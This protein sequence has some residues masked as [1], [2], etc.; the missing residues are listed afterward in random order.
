MGICAIRSAFA[1]PAIAVTRRYFFVA[2]VANL[3]WEVAQLPFYTIWETGTLREISFAILHCTVG[4]VIIAAGALLLALLIAGS[5]AWPQGD[6][7]AVSI[8]IVV[9]GAGY[10]VFSEWLNVSVRGTWAYTSAMPVVPPFGT[11]L[12]PLLQWLIVPPLGIFL[13]TRTTRSQS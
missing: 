6:H 11:G 5:E 3:L 10:T 13:T 7:A 8:A 4:D 12:T 2:L 9:F 1:T